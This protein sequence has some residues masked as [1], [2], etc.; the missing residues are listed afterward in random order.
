M[1]AISMS[2]RQI[3]IVAV[4]DVCK[5]KAIRAAVEGPLGNICSG[6]ILRTHDEANLFLDRES[7]G[8]LDR[9]KLA[10]AT[11]GELS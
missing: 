1:R 7:A 6:S 8:L 2:I 11:L 3:P 5:A 4:P 9:E 10:A